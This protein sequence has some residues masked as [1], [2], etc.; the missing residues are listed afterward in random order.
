MEFW[1]DDDELLDLTDKEKKLIKRYN[2]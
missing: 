2:L 1:D